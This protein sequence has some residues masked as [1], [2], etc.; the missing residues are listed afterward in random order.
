VGVD[1]LGDYHGGY[2]AMPRPI[3]S[4]PHEGDLETSDRGQAPLVHVLAELEP[5]QPS[6]PGGV[7][8][9]EIAGDLEQLLDS[10]G[11]RATTGAIVGSQILALTSAEQPPDVPDRAVGDGQLGRDLGQGHALLVPAY[12]LL[13]ER[14]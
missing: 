7:F 14:D 13:A 5:D 9:F 1:R 8:A 11:N 2:A 4:G 10:P 6:A 12:D 3:D